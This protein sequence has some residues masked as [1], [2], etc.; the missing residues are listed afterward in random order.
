MAHK[1]WSSDSAPSPW[2][3]TAWT[4]FV[5]TNGQCSN[6]KSDR[7]DRLPLIRSIL[8]VWYGFNGYV[9]PTEP[10]SKSPYHHQEFDQCSSGCWLKRHQK[11]NIWKQR[12][13]ILSH[14][15]F[16]P[17]VADS[18][19]KNKTDSV[20][21]ISMWH[22]G[23]AVLLYVLFD[24]AYGTS[25]L[26]SSSWRFSAA[27]SCSPVA[28]TEHT[29]KQ[30]K[31]KWTYDVCSSLCLYTWRVAFRLKTGEDRACLVKLCTMFEQ[32][33]KTIVTIYMTCWF[34][35]HPLCKFIVK[36]ALQGLMTHFWRLHAWRGVTDSPAKC[37]T[38]KM[39]TAQTVI[40]KKIGTCSTCSESNG[41]SNG[42][43]IPTN[44]VMFCFSIFLEMTIGKYY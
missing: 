9:M 17:L 43:W 20:D 6:Q 37:W 30:A 35:L 25:S 21:R 23:V 32:L 28:V 19:K 44:L 14:R 41:E 7:S 1:S 34:L 40:P 3:S 11:A 18:G 2:L 4:G 38:C 15:N 33:W 8:A 36:V 10:G 13:I 12:A 29:H 16:K 5:V 24:A 42:R 39:A 27:A 31:K 22:S 26:S